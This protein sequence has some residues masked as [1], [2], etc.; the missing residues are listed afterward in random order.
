MD[1]FARLV[2]LIDAVAG[3]LT[4]FFLIYTKLIRKS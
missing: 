1:D 2:L 3:S 4:L